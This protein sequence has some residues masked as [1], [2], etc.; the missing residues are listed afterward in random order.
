MDWE[1]LAR[2]TQTAL[3]FL[4]RVVDVNFYPIDT[5][6]KSNRAWRPVGLGLMGLQDLFFKME[7]PFE[8]EQARL[9]S[10]K[11]QEKIYYHALSAS[12]DLAREK[13]PHDK[14]PE[15]RA[16]QGFLQ[17]DLWGLKP[18]D[19]KQW[20]SLK[21]RIKKWG[22][23]NSLVLAVAPTATI[24]SI[25]GAYESIEPQISNLFKRETL[26]GEFIQINKYLVRRLKKL[27]LWSAV[28]KE[29]L[30]A[31]EGSVQNISEIPNSIKQLFKTAWELPQKSLIDMALARGPYIDQSQS[32]NLF[33][34]N[35]T[36]NRLSSMYMYAWKN[37]LKTSYYLRSRPATNIAKVT[38]KP[39]N[40][41]LGGKAIDLENP[42]TCEACQ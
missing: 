39:L 40:A 16:A 9:L 25:V 1:K 7:I 2:N 37:G 29:K 32:L 38:I 35:P 5:A 17:F 23:R 10:A 42:K 4:D 20:N 14:F 12:C 6:K 31:C 18:S 41:G 3:K 8:S 21:A 19:E 28:I 30:K 13:G 26:S 15:S 34:E 11:I 33:V 36:I 24:A 27:G 22:L